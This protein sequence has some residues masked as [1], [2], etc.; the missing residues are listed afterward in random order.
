MKTLDMLRDLQVRAMAKMQD[1]ELGVRDKACDFYR[2]LIEAEKDFNRIRAHEEM[3]AHEASI[4]Q[5]IDA[6]GRSK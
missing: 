6:C 3:T 1:E 2:S 4:R 5:A